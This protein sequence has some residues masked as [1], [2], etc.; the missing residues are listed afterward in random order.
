MKGRGRGKERGRS[1]IF[2]TSSVTFT[3]AIVE[4]REGIENPKIHQAPVAGLAAGETG[5]RREKKEEGGGSYRRPAAFS[6]PRALKEKERKGGRKAEQFRSP[7]HLSRD[8]LLLFSEREKTIIRKDPKN[9][10]KKKKKGGARRF[11]TGFFLH[12]VRFNWQLRG[13]KKKKKEEDLLI[14]VAS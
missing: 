13:K 3:A 11:S 1:R 14:L 9:K 6:Y 7:G 2:S 8:I 12:G 10:E 5:G 4:R